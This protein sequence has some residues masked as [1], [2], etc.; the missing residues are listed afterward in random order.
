MA[1]STLN[2]PLDSDLVRVYN[3]T[4]EEEREKIQ[5]L[6]ALWLREIASPDRVPLG[7]LVDAISDKAQARD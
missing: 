6:L 3:A 5:A 1:M 7:E 4:S 2:I